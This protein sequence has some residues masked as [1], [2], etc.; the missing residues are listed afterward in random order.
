MV[1]NIINLE[2]KLVREIMTPRTMM[3]S[4][5]ATMTVQEAIQSISG[6]GFTRIPIYEG[7]KENITGYVVTHD[8]N[9][10]EMKNKPESTLKSIARQ[11]S[12]VPENINC[13]T[14][15]TNFLKQRKH[16]AIVTDE[17]G[18][19]D[20][21]ITLEDLLETVLG[22]EIVDETD[23]IVDLQEAARKRKPGQPED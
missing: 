12:F 2:E 1:F 20:G 21:M 17:Y 5:P 15:L 6:K 16:I 11:I 23:I 19:V 7:D 3:F 18:G 4:L 13:L 8:I 14:M 22:S 9:F 10:T